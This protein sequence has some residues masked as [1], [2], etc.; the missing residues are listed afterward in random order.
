MSILS[1][2]RWNLFKCL[3]LTSA[4]TGT[5]VMDSRFNNLGIY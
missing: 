3:S 2:Y 5:N 1:K 4:H